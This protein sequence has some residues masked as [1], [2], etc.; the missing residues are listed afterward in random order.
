MS[1]IIN[2][3]TLEFD[4]SNKC[5]NT[6]QWCYHN[7]V[8][9]ENSTSP[10]NFKKSLQKFFEINI[11]TYLENFALYGGNILENKHFLSYLDTLEK[12]DDKIHEYLFSTTFWEYDTLAK[13]HQNKLLGSFFKNKKFIFQYFFNPDSTDEYIKSC[14]DLLS[15]R[16]ETY[17][18]FSIQLV[19]I[20]KNYLK[21][22]IEQLRKFFISVWDITTQDLQ[23]IEK[24]IT[25][26]IK[27][28]NRTEN[29][30]IKIGTYTFLIMVLHP[31]RKEKNT[32]TSVCWDSCSFYSSSSMK[33]NTFNS[34]M[35]SIEYDGAIN[36]HN[37]NCIASMQRICN[38]SD[39]TLI[40]DSSLKEFY[41]FLHA[42]IHS[43]QNLLESCNS[44]LKY[45]L[46][47][48]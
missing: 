14:K 3:K 7:K 45:N 34:S 1:K 44:C 6:C 2:I 29:F 42:N 24:N 13:L 37:P 12:F 10:E 4:V 8:I 33:E 22:L 26:A 40:I 9:T 19:E 28:K 41:T 38:I 16:Y 36:F 21:N 5:G 30:K 18:F 39:D 43:S 46:G 47:K 25:Q 11:S 27:E 35:L 32:I 15:F 17:V 48:K 23:D 20:E 31:V